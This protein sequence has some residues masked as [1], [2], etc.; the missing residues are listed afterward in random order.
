MFTEIDKNYRITNKNF[1]K[2]SNLNVTS[3]LSY[4][5]YQLVSVVYRS[6]M[7]RYSKITPLKRIS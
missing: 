7:R 4:I 2:C 1:E 3:L 6:Q 5:K